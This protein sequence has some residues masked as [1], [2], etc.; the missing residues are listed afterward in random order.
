MQKKKVILVT[1]NAGFIGYHVAKSLMSKRTKIIGIDNINSYYD[2]KVKIARLKD[3]KNHSN[4][5]N[6]FYI[7]KK[8]DIDKENS[9]KY[10]FKK[11]KI[12]YVIHLAAQAGVRYSILHPEQYIKSNI[13]AF[14]NILQCC[15]FFRIKHLLY[16]STSSVYG[17]NKKIPFEEKD[18]ADHPIQLYAATK[19]S[20]EL[21]A[22][23]FSHLFN[24]PTTGL[25]FF[26]VYGPWGRPDMALF[27][28]TKNILKNKYIEVYN[29]GDH[30]RDFTYIDDVVKI[31]KKLYLKIPKKNKNWNERN[32]SSS[33]SPFR[34]LN[35]GNGQKVKLLK[36]IEY[37]EK[38][39][40][41][42]AK[43]KYL[44]K[45]LGDVRAALS[46]T[47]ELKRI[48]NYVPK[49]SVKEG[50]KKFIE[51]YKSFYIK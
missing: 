28:F 17:A 40:N 3:L 39:L 42:K 4:K 18:V 29:Y 34:I 10:I 30:V 22:H 38:G 11:F 8:I 27:K 9:L 13:K 23:S 7:F 51:W 50:V 41:R 1:G 19:R 37:I 43:I 14:S 2:T 49:I 36:Y 31:I 45:Q 24:L 6:Y 21:M 5:N 16:A 25:R 32:P 48:I 26:T 35:V 15:N 12:N 47:K 33:S 20:N 44:P 46:S